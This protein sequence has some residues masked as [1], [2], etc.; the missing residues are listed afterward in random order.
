MQLAGEYV[1]EITEEVANAIGERN[2][3]TLRAFASENSA[4]LATLGRRMTSYWSCYHRSAYPERNSYPG[5]RVLAVM[6]A[7]AE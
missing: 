1:V 5:A 2:P 3:A 6:N 7:P 4:Y